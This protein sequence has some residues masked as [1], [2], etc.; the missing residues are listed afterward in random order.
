MKKIYELAKKAG[1][2][3]IGLQDIQKSK[4]INDL[5]RLLKTGK[6]IKFIM[7]SNFLTDSVYN[8]YRSELEKGEYLLG[9]STFTCNTFPVVRI[10]F[11]ILYNREIYFN[12]AL[13]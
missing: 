5:I 12:I 7:E 11:F 2:C 10:L 4:S 6:G 1:A 8:Q 9:W 3:S 13:R